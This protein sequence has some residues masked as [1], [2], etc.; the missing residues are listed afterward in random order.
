MQPGRRRASDKP[1]KARAM[2]A[3]ERRVMDDTV[4]WQEMS[5]RSGV[6]RGHLSQWFRRNTYGFRDAAAKPELHPPLFLWSIVGPLIEAVK[7]H[8]SKDKPDHVGL[9]ET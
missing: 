4:T 5:E 3:A 6:P 8:D 1:P 7:T 9:E 2:T